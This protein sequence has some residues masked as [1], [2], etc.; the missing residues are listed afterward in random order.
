MDGFGFDKTALEIGVDGACGPGRC[1]AG[2]NRPCADF[3]FVEG[4]EGPESKQLV[5][6]VNER[7]YTTFLDAKFLEIFFGFVRRKVAQIALQL[8]ANSHRIAGV[9]NPS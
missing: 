6:A 1:L 2:V 9:M 4:K 3:L 5:S 7:R 8:R